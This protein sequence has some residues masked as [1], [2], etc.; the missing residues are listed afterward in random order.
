MS[1][2]IPPRA[3]M[4]FQMNGILPIASELRTIEHIGYTPAPDIVHEAV[5]HVP[6]LKHPVFSQFLKTY[7]ETVRK[8][9]VSREDMKQYAAIRELSDLKEDPTAHPEDIQRLEDNLNT[10]NEESAYI[11][12]ASYLSRFIWWTSEYGLAGDVKNPKI[13]GAG[14][15]SSV[16]ESRRILSDKVKKLPLTKDCLNYKYDITD[17]QPQLF[18]TPDFDHLLTI[19]DEIAQTL[20][21]KRGGIFGVKQAV[22]SQTINT[23]VLNSGLQISG[24]VESFMSKGESLEFIKFKGPT[25][26][27]FQNRELPGQ[28]KDY[29]KEG[30][31]TPLRWMGKDNAPAWLMTDED[32]RKQGLKPGTRAEIKFPGDI[33]LKGEMTHSLRKEGRLLLVTFKNCEIRRGDTLLFHPDWGPFDLGIGS[34]VLSVFS[35][36]ADERAYG[37]KDTFQP[38]VIS[39]KSFSKRDREIFDIY[40]NIEELKTLYRSCLNVPDQKKRERHEFSNKNS[41]KSQDNKKMEDKLNALIQRVFQGDERLWLAGLELLKTA[42]DFPQQKAQIESGLDLLEKNHSTV[43]E[44][45]KNGRKFYA[46]F[47]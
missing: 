31:S 4:D 17:F 26:L 8:A 46:D 5:G 20:S 6:F 7:A 32:L 10:I 27:S 43:R 15:I 14:L 19:L 39:P 25:Q 33:V 22:R 40:R 47:V 42:R 24:L 21:Y 13:F 2:F 16:S 35:R 44:H 29:H 12:E 23:V 38:S 9:I 41:I 37:L 3:F 30:Y 11:S 28:G 18:V 1:G 34:R 36:P 45:I